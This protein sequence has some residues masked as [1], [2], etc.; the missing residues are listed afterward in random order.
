MLN[1]MMDT[2]DSGA[3][4]PAG[5]PGPAA[6]DAQLATGAG[7]AAP[8]A[9]AI[10][11]PNHP[12][13]PPAEPKHENAGSKMLHGILNALGGTEERAYRR[14]E[15]GHLVVTHTKSGPGQ[16]WK[17]IV[18]GALAG[19]AAATREK[20]GP[21]QVSRAGGAGFQGGMDLA[22]GIEQRKIDTANQ[23]FETMDRTT[24]RKAQTALITQQLSEKAFQLGRAKIQSS[25]DDAA[26]ENEFSAY[27]KAG[28][29]GSQDLGVVRNFEELLQ[30]NDNMPN[31][32][33]EHANG[34]II[35]IPHV[36]DKGE[37]EGMHYAL[38]T[39]EWKGAKLDSDRAYYV[40]RPPKT[41]GGKPALERQ[42]VKAGTMTN[43]EYEL[44]RSANEKQIQEWYEKQ[45]VQQ[46][47]TARAGEQNKTTIEA[48]HIGA[49]A[50]VAVASG[51]KKL[52]ND[53]AKQADMLETEY[54]KAQEYLAKPSG[55]NDL[56]ILFSYVRSQVA[57]A[58]RM[59]NVEI[60]KSAE[61]GSF[62]TRVSSMY[63]KATSGTLD[64]EL[65]AQM[66][67]SIGIAA[68]AA[69]ATADKYSAQSGSEP[70]APG[71]TQEPPPPAGATSKVRDKDGKLIG[72]VVQ[73]KYVAL[74]EAK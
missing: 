21:G 25:F 56:A 31:L 59:T 37:L 63:S 62:G 1:D 73:G 58:G 53:S 7:V 11:P 24:L 13:V 42:T 6:P 48:A 66:V 35:S 14:D 2:Q 50:R 40:L 36:N 20:P 15:S 46:Q 18:A 44:A 43:G 49:N 32:A 72:H 5:A 61:A 52:A 55:P 64:P 38:V 28:G 9:P 54:K 33:K 47:E 71:S 57:G 19:A 12:A 22:Q 8:S 34:N 29:N 70:I 60:Q 74:P 26:R 45:Y 17:R 69:R 16:Q 10:L 4:T 65:K 51:N 67:D 41:Q 39:P 27:I 23:D 68:R 30:M 3:N